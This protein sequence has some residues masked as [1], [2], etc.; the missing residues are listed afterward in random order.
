[1]AILGVLQYQIWP[2]TERIRTDL[3]A[4]NFE[5]LGIFIVVGIFHRIFGAYL[6][7]LKRVLSANTINLLMV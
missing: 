3:Q 6:H 2:T 4:R 1:M 5:H 7:M